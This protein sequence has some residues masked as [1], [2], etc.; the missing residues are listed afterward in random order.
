VPDV[1]SS[2]QEPEQLTGVTGAEAPA[3]DFDLLA[4][5]LEFVAQDSVYFPPGKSGN[6]V[7][8]AFGTMFRQLV[9]VDRCH[10]ER[11]CEQRATCAYA[12]IFEPV[13]QA[14][15]GP[16]GLHD[17]PRPF[18][19]RAAH[20][21]GATI[22]AGRP[23]SFD[24]H[25]FDMKDPAIVYFVLAFAQVAQEGIGPRRGRARLARASQLDAGGRPA[26]CV[27]N[28]A[29]VPAELLPPIHLEFAPDAEPVTKAQV[30]FLTPTEL[31]HGQLLA[32]RPEFPVLFGRIR[33]R[34]ST[35]RALYGA[36]PLGIDFKA[37]GERAAAVKMTDCSLRF[38]EAER[39]SARTGERHPLGGF[40]GEVTY[41]GALG[42]FMPYLRAAKWV[43]VGRQTVW[44]KGVTEVQVL[45]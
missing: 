8:G 40:V 38:S 23:F 34:I 42:E 1:E 18:V 29:F 33:D 17:W 5:R 24:V 16:S 45:G 41:E 13:A 9:C 2:R 21:D 3:A 15:E 12:R 20:L 32:T 6:I 43:G 11:T 36:G 26:A 10:D 25:L 31:K 28:G 30:R 35:L 27:Y 4:F 44:G 7:R 14:A 19:F 22:E 37:L 39:R